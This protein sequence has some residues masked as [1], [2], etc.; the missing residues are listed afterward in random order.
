MEGSATFGKG[1]S[2]KWYLTTGS[3]KGNGGELEAAPGNGQQ[4]NPTVTA[5]DLRS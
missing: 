3:C 2:L 1:R 5:K 4:G